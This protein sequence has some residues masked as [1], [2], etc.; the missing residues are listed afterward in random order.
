MKVIVGLGNPGKQYADTRHNVGFRAIDAYVIQLRMPEFS[1]KAQFNAEIAKGAD[2]I[3]IKPQTF[4]NN[5]GQA[6]RTVLDYFLNWNAASLDWLYVIHDDLDLV[7]GTFKL[8]LGTGPKEHNGLLSLYQH[9]GTKQFWHARIGIDGR[10]GD[11]SIPPDRYVLLSPPP[12]EF[13]L[14]DESI[15]NV[16]SQIEAVAP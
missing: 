8:Q 4:V 5:S 15:K 9:L 11:R 13:K 3:F 12:H 1:F 10:A 6:V 7:V 2:Y 14:V 16:I